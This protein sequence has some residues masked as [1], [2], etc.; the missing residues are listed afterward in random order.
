M[1]HAIL[2]MLSTTLNSSQLLS[3]ASESGSQSEISVV[4]NNH[5]QPHYPSE[6]TS[7]FPVPVKPNTIAAT[8]CPIIDRHRRTLIRLETDAFCCLLNCGGIR[9]AHISGSQ[10]LVAHVERKRHG[11]PDDSHRSQQTK[12][13]ASQGSNCIG[14]PSQLRSARLV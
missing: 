12:P 4:V 14:D 7:L 13:Y 6:F 9:T 11:R 10:L 8:S 5:P 1:E 3:L 2:S